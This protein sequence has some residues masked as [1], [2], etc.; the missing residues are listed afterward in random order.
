MEL[1]NILISLTAV[2]LA[3]FRVVKEFVNMD[4]NPSNQK[5]LC[6]NKEVS[7][8]SFLPTNR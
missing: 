4:L 1:W 7:A 8:D 2:W 5:D 6:I 3:C